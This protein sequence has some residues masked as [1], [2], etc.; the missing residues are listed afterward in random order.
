MTPRRALVAYVAPFLI[1]MGGL[2]LA[3]IFHS[4]GKKS[5]LL[6]LQRPEY[7]VYPLQTIACA[8]ALIFY[9]REYDWGRQGAWPAAIFSGL[10][11]LGIW[12]SPQIFFHA[13]RRLEGFDPSLFIENPLLYWLT[14]IARF[15][16][17]VIIVPLVE[18]IFWRG[19]LMRY[20]ISED[21]KKVPLGT[22]RP[23]SFIAVAVLFMLGHGTGDWP[24]AFL[25]GLLYNG[26]AVYTRSLSAC[27]LAHATTNLGLGIYIMS[28]RQW[29]FW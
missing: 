3:E 1:F 26:L 2:A 19:F 10:V 6:L 28:T 17:L 23:F 15:G 4:F 5:D 27:I 22:F 13:P 11:A 18:E 9:W 25:C 12:I 16:R 14:I 24:A 8:I 29:G 21:F 7:W 20:F